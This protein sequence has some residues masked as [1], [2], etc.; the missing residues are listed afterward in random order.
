M[1]KPNWSFKEDILK[2]GLSDRFTKADV[3]AKTI[4]AIGVAFAVSLRNQGVEFGPE[5]KCNV[6]IDEDHDTCFVKYKGVFLTVMLDRNVLMKTNNSPFYFVKSPDEDC[7]VFIE[8]MKQDLNRFQ[9][10]K[11]GNSKELPN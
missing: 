11:T 2:P 4:H 7:Q 10:W 3:F 9:Q 6:G 8:L 1:L 5:E